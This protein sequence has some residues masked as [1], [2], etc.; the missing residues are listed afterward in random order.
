MGG[1]AILPC[2][3][4]IQENWLELKSREEGHFSMWRTRSRFTSDA[5]PIAEGRDEA[6]AEKSDYRHRRLL[7]TRRERYSNDCAAE[8]SCEFAPADGRRRCSSFFWTNGTAHRELSGVTHARK[9]W[10]ECRETGPVRLIMCHAH[11]RATSARLTCR[12]QPCEFKAIAFSP[13]LASRVRQITAR[14]ETA[15]LR[16]FD[17]AYDRLGSNAPDRQAPDARGMSASPRKRP[18]LIK[19]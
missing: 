8:H 1:Y 14:Q 5:Q 17:R 4:S 2:R 9:L 3:G 18:S 11:R 10:I 19:M 12:R 7:Y 16:E 13:A 6:T 15:A